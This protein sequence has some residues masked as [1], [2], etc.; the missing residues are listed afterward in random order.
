MAPYL[1]FLGC[2]TYATFSRECEYPDGKHF[3]IELLVP[4]GSS[5]VLAGRALDILNDAILWVNIFTGR[6]GM[7]SRRFEAGFTGW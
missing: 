5:P 3:G 4:P 6:A 1:F 7:T 2:G